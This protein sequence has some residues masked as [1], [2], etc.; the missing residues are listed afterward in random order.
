MLNIRTKSTE[1]ILLLSE[2]DFRMNYTSELL[3]Y[4]EDVPSFKV[5][6]TLNFR[7]NVIIRGTQDVKVLDAFNQ[8]MRVLSQTVD[9]IIITL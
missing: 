6:N 9:R 5:G 3:A 7:T 1:R 2:E 4:L 8:Y